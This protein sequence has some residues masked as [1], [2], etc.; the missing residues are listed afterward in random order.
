MEK[1]GAGRK[2][3]MLKGRGRGAQEVLGYGTGSTRELEV[4]LLLLAILKGG[5]VKFR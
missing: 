5:G 1:E 2:S 4:L 3:A